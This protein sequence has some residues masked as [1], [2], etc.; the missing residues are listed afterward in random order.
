MSA[1]E[2]AAVA[3]RAIDAARAELDRCDCVGPAADQYLL[4]I[5]AWQNVMADIRE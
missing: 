3:Q 5:R 2:L 4:I 1:A